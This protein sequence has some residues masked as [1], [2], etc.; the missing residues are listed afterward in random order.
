[1]TKQREVSGR[2]T[3]A[4]AVGSLVD[5]GRLRF[6]SHARST[7]GNRTSDDEICAVADQDDRIV[8]TKDDD[9]MYSFL[10]E[11]KPGRLLLL[12]TGNITNAELSGLFRD[13]LPVLE[14]SFA[15]SDFVEL[16]RDTILLHE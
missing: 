16:R 12:S 8:V 13:T 15:E 6:Y 2:C 3:A 5:R 14:E 1:M 9:F 11:G 4:A 10:V 7:G